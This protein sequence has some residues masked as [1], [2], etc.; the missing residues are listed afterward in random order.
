MGVTGQSLAGFLGYHDA[1][2]SP[3]SIDG[4]ERWGSTPPV[5]RVAAAGATPRYVREVRRA[6]E[7]INSALPRSWQLTFDPTLRPDADGEFG[8]EEGH[9]DNEITVNFYT[10]NRGGFSRARYGR[11]PDVYG[12]D[13]DLHTA[14]RISIGDPTSGNHRLALIIHE[15][16]HALGI[17]GDTWGEIENLWPRSIM[18]YQDGQPLRPNG[19]Q[20]L[21]RL[22]RDSFLALYTVLAPGMTPDEITAALAGWTATPTG[23][24]T[25]LPSLTA[26]PSASAHGPGAHGPSR[27]RT[28]PPLHRRWS[29]TRP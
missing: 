16:G 3:F 11:E 29:T 22:D 7:I 27:G 20:M 2:D 8:R 21:Y 25:A 15:I 9:F 14:A 5:V 1:N 24:R 4:L 10:E 19:R 18:T 26:R 6:V 13:T 23:S 28:S 12:P 17:G